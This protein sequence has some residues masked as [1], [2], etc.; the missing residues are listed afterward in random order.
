MLARARIAGLAC[1]AIGGAAAVAAVEDLDPAALSAGAFTLARF[2][3]EAFSEPAPGLDLPQIQ[4][5]MRGRHH[6]NQPWVV[7]PSLAGDWGLGPTFISDRC[8]GCH[9]KA[10][11]GNVPSGADEQLVSVLVRI[12]I[13]GEGE[14]GA[15]KPHPHYGDQL[16]NQGLMGQ[17]V[18]STFLGDR[19]PAEAELY[20][21]WEERTVTLADGETLQ[22]RR[23][24]LRIE[25]PT[26]GALGPEVMYSL[27][28][29]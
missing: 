21:D 8:S 22:L 26:F 5:F 11:R 29:A 27:R 6:F 10:G 15:P 1:L 9:V 3:T 25:K 28:M 24:K 4:K 20:L 12:S 16:Q 23:P 18:E 14:H 19:V 2:D 7:F 13:P 17:K